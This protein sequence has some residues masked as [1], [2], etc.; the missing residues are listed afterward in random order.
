ML[1]CFPSTAFTAVFAHI[2]RQNFKYA[3]TFVLLKI[4]SSFINLFDM[5]QILV[6]VMNVFEN[7]D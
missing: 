7:K 4:S 6:S 1:Q 2:C 3:K 5:L